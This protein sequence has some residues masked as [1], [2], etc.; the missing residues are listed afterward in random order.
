[1]K[2]ISEQLSKVNSFR[3][4]GF[5]ELNGVLYAVCG[6]R[7]F[8]FGT[9]ATAR[10]IDGCLT[11]LKT[12]EPEMRATYL[13]G[14][15]AVAAGSGEAAVFDPDGK[16]IM[17]S[18]ALEGIPFGASAGD[19]YLNLIPPLRLSFSPAVGGARAVL[20]DPFN[21]VYED[22][23]DGFNGWGAVNLIE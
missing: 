1:M 3:G 5:L 6:S 16:P 10:W 2:V 19:P 22:G 18:G 9:R 13:V 4:L 15:V 12:V 21:P 11:L 14:S 17:Y 23:A 20:F 7:Q 8:D